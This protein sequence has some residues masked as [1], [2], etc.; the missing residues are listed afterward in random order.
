MVAFHTAAGIVALLTGLFIVFSPK[1]TAPHKMAGKV[2]VLGMY[3]VCLTSF[4]ISGL[5]DGYGIFHVIAVVGMVYLTIGLVPMVA[6]RRFRRWYPMHFYMMLWSFVGLVMALDGHFSLPVYRLLHSTLGLS[7]GAASAVGI[8]L[9][10]GVPLVVGH[11]MIDRKMRDFR[12]QF[13]IAP[14]GEATN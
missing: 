7:R 14:D 6:K 1:G 11:L 5:F 4:W 2:Y 10:W 12:R 8:A 3:A 9:L 13:A